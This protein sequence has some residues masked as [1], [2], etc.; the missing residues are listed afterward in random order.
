MKFQILF[1]RDYKDPFIYGLSYLEFL[2]KKNSFLKDGVHHSDP[3]AGSLKNFLTYSIVQLPEIKLKDSVTDKNLLMQLAVQEKQFL[4]AN[5]IK[6][7]LL[8]GEQ[9][10]TEVAGVLENNFLQYAKGTVLC[11]R[12]TNLGEMAILYPGFLMNADSAEIQISAAKAASSPSNKKK[13]IQQL[14]VSRVMTDQFDDNFLA[15]SFL[16]IPQE[17][18]DIILNFSEIVSFAAGGIAGPILAGLIG[19]VHALVDSSLTGSMSLEQS[20][21]YSFKSLLDQREIQQTNT[22]FTTTLTWYKSEYLTA[23]EAERDNMGLGKMLSSLVLDPDGLV[24]HINLL[25]IEDGENLEKSFKF[26]AFP[27]FIAGV[28]LYQTLAIALIDYLHKKDD[29]N[30]FYHAIYIS[31]TL[32]LFN[33]HGQTMYDSILKIISDRL[34]QISG[35]NEKWVSSRNYYNQDEVAHGYSCTYFTDSALPAYF[36][37]DIPQ[38]AG[39]YPYLHPSLCADDVPDV[40]KAK[41]GLKAYIDKVHQE[42]SARLFNLDDEKIQKTLNNWQTTTDYFKKLAAKAV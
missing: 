39:E 32:R 1:S 13:Q 42:Y 25:K 29:K 16:G 23:R 8:P 6:F 36:M 9:I 2:N 31:E 15:D 27:A 18:L 20:M 4:A 19:V 37:D 34:G 11:K 41:T 17:T 26:K 35:L 30:I 40:E 3:D 21:T 38:C 5:A 28:H 22:K 33:D 24:Y 7:P 14:E 12:T 10:Q